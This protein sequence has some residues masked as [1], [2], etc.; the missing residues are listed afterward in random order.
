[1]AP[2]INPYIKANPVSCRNRILRCLNSHIVKTREQNT[3]KYI[4]VNSIFFLCNKNS[5]IRCTYLSKSKEK[6]IKASS[7]NQADVAQIVFHQLWRLVVF[8]HLEAFLHQKNDLVLDLIPKF[9]IF[10]I[11][12]GH[13]YFFTDCVTSILIRFLV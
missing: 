1:M 12:W 3:Y 9:P 11:Y 13:Y 6:Y 2:I 10:S 8:D 7:K 5:L 4:E